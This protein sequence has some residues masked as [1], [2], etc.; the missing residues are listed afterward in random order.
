MSRGDINEQIVNKKE[1][2][3]RKASD[4][5]HLIS[6]SQIDVIPAIM[7]ITFSLIER[8]YVTFTKKIY[9]VP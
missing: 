2:F 6:E 1:P 7:A 8:P 5:K 4:E 9:D 3:D